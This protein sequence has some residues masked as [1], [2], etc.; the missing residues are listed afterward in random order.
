[1]TQKS[2]ICR[3]KLDEMRSNPF[4]CGC[5]L[6]NRERAK[7]LT[8][9]EGRQGPGEIVHPERSYEAGQTGSIRGGGR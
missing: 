5:P 2:V 3:R 8:L 6:C 1:M 9:G 4:I 7:S